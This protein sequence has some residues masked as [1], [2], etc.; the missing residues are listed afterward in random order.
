MGPSE[1]YRNPTFIAW[2]DAEYPCEEGESAAGTADILRDDP[3][4][5]KHDGPIYDLLKPINRRYQGWCGVLQLRSGRV[6]CPECGS[7][8]VDNVGDSV[9][10]LCGQCEHEW[11]ATWPPEAT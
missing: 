7:W 1:W 11:H 5:G 8:D 10:A 3:L 4:A 9:V 6:V 2:H